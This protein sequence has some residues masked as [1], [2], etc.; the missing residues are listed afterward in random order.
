MIG[1]A[2]TIGFEVATGFGGA[3]LRG[4]AAAIPMADTNSATLAAILT[5]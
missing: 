2:G 3:D 5:S 1:F 4:C